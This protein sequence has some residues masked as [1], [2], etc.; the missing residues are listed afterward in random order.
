[1]SHVTITFLFALNKQHFTNPQR[2]GTIMNHSNTKKMQPNS[3]TTII[4]HLPSSFIVVV[5][6]C[7]LLFFTQQWNSNGYHVECSVTLQM[8]EMAIPEHRSIQ[9]NANETFDIFVGF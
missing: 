9:V 5:V 2:E 4:R 1:M 7:S 3:S 6:F 8:K